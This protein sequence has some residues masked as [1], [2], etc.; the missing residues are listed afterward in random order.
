[1]D[2]G[3]KIKALRLKAGVTQEKMAQELGVSCQAISKWENNV[4]APDISMLPK[5]SIFFGVTIDELF[6]LTVNQKLHR[7]ENML[8]FEEELSDEDFKETVAFL[9]EQQETYTEGKPGRIYSF[10]AHVYH[11][12]MLSDSVKVSDYARKAMR[13][14]PDIKEDQWLLDKAEGAYVCDWNYRNHHKTILFF[15]EQVENHPQIS[16]NYLY[17][18]DN[19]LADNRTEE[20][21]RYLDIYRGLKDRQEFQILVYETR[22]ALAEHKPEAAAQ[23]LKEIEERFPENPGVLF[24]MAGF[25]AD[26]CNYEEALRYYEKSYGL[27]KKPRYNDALRGE[28]TIYEI[29]EKYE[30]ALECWDRIRQNLTEEWGIREGAPLLEVEKEKQRIINRVRSKN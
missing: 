2:L 25:H 7:I 5:L 8:D 3:N 9:K 29:Q 26:A 28:A 10:L 18:M 11:H 19:L 21:R 16:R 1:M 30:E 27:E 12:R 15:R 23:K 13:L 22:I 6:D 4:C 24:E 14:H 17:L 20:T